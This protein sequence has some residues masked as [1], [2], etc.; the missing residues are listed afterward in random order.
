MHREVFAR[1]DKG[2]EEKVFLKIQ[3]LKS[4]FSLLFFFSMIII[5]NSDFL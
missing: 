1:N 4:F 5:V 3:F 2:K